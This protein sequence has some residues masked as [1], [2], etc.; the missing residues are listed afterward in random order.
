MLSK[1]LFDVSAL[2]Y[3]EPKKNTKH[4]NTNAAFLNTQN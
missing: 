3:K 1:T 2:L 4:P